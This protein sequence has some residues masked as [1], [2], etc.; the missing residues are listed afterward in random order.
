MSPFK[1]N[2]ND[3]VTINASGESGQII[4]RAEY[5]T[6]ENSYLLRY[7]AADGRACESWWTESALVS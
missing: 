2:L 4:G 5:A 6:S 1:F 3:N 7:K